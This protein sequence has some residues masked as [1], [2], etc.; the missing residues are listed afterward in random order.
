[1]SVLDSSASVGVL[2][3]IHTYHTRIDI[4]SPHIFPP[5]THLPM[6]VVYMYMCI[7]A[8]HI[9]P[10]CK[11]GMLVLLPCC[12]RVA[13]V[14]L[15]TVSPLI[16]NVEYFAA[17]LPGGAACSE[18]T[19]RQQNDSNMMAILE[20]HTSSF[21]LERHIHLCLLHVQVKISDKISDK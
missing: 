13:A 15:H 11:H 7:C 8:I 21:L 4:F 1:M 14:L 12:D 17:G 2:C 18:E 10:H 16:A 5:Y 19:T 3:A 6:C 20:R 9:P